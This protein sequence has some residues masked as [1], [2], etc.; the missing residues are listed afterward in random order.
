MREVAVKAG[1]P[2]NVL[3]LMIRN[4]RAHIEFD[5]ETADGTPPRGTVETSH[6]SYVLG[7]KKTALPL[8]PSHT[9]D[10][11]WNHHN[12][13]IHVTSETDAV[14]RFRTRHIRDVH[15]YGAL[16]VVTA[17]VVAGVFIRAMIVNG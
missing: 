1:V 12:F 3:T 8:L 5:V 2:T 7:R 16:A 14:V 4:V 6:G 13:E 17:V 15:V 9:F 10:K 11:P